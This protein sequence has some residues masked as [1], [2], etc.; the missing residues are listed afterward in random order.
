[1]NGFFFRSIVL[2]TVISLNITTAQIPF[3]KELQTLTLLSPAQKKE[4][5]NA[6]TTL[7][8]MYETQNSATPA[9]TLTALQAKSIAPLFSTNYFQLLAKYLSNPQNF[10]TTASPE[11]KNYATMHLAKTM[12][13]LA[14]VSNI[15]FINNAPKINFSGDNRDFGVIINIK[16][17]TDS[18]FSIYQ[19]S[20]DG[21][22]KTQIG[23]V[24]AGINP[25]N[26][27]TAAL[28]NPQPKNAK[29]EQP[30][31]YYF[32]FYELNAENPTYISIRMY[33]GQELINFL[34]TLPRKDK[35]NFQMNGLPTGK[36]YLAHQ[37]DCYM[38]LIQNPTEK[39]QPEQNIDQRIQAINI[40]KLSGPYL[41]KMQIN[42]SSVEIT[43]PSNKESKTTELF[44]PSFT[45]VF[46]PNNQYAS[47]T[48]CPFIILPHFLWTVPQI[49]TLWMLN[50]TTYI[51]ALTQYKM[52]GANSFGKAFSY[53]EQLGF[54]DITNDY[55]FFIDHYNIL[56]YGYF[57]YNALWLLSSGLY[58]TDLNTCS[59]IPQIYTAQNSFGKIIAN[60][61]DFYDFTFL[62]IFEPANSQAASEKLLE[63]KG[64]NALYALPGYQLYSSI[65]NA[66]QKEVKQGIFGTLTKIEDNVYK[67]TYSNKKNKILSSQYLYLD[68]PISNIQI[69]FV[70]FEQETNWT[71]TALPSNLIPAQ[72]GETTHFKVT[73]EYSST[74]NKHILLTQPTSAIDK[75][76]V[77]L[78]LY[79]SQYP[80]QQFYID[81][82]HK[83]NTAPY[84]RCFIAQDGIIPAPLDDL[85]EQDW[86]NGIY[87]IPTIA[88]NDQITPSNPGALTLVFYKYD[89]TMIGKLTI[90]GQYNNTTETGIR[91]PITAYNPHFTDTN[92]L[93]DLYL[94][95]GVLLRYNP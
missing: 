83:F 13:R 67:L 14:S 1:M 52:V 79:F 3:Q 4:L 90:D 74:N 61:Q 8:Q 55:C 57:L 35:N 15:S 59:D 48:Q 21:K 56:K 82:F 40:S 22:I 66:L 75:Q 7:H 16:N 63:T 44:Q 51:A 64:I 12:A 37:Q 92:C 5:T 68:A 47:L 80:I 45:N 43:T 85:A 31:A 27:H 89:K 25:V 17:N 78:P 93:I 71:G 72:P 76:E 73:Y 30:S 81:V 28:Q 18:Q 34:E 69:T 62:T 77:I 88:N 36:E 84:T 94:T 24:V 19:S 6:W 91:E 58:E 60:G 32:D 54:F 42:Q 95:T 70:N 10:L 38:V 11:Q 23:Q 50:Y 39:T 2:S 41:L 53:F 9:T 49:K 29:T 65:T 46:I 87:M 86:K 26:L 33:T 20:L